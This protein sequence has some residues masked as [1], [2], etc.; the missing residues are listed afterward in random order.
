MSIS[1]AFYDRVAMNALAT[2]RWKKDVR[3]KE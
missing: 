2:R 3:R 1:E